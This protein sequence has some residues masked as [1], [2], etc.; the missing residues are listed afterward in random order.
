LEIFLKNKINIFSLFSEGSLKS[1][2]WSLLPLEKTEVRSL[3]L[4]TL[5]IKTE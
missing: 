2:A 4:L 1:D 5:L 3:L